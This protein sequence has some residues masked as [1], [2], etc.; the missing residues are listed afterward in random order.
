M[1]TKKLRSVIRW[2]VLCL[3]GVVSGCKPQ[4]NS[5]EKSLLGTGPQALT[6]EQVDDLEE[7]IL[8]TMDYLHVP[9]ASV[10]I[11]LDGEVIYARGFGVRDL[12]TK[13]PVTPQ[14]IM[15]IGST[16]K[17]MTT[18]MMASMVDEGI[19]S[20]DT[21]V[22]DI[23]PSITLPTPELTQKMTMQDLVCNC[24]GIQEQKEWEFS[25]F[26]N[27]VAEDIIEN[28]QNA[29]VRGTYQR[30]F[31]YNSN[32]I[33]SGGFLAALAAG[34]TYGNLY[35]AYV[36]EMQARLLD[37]AGMAD[38]TF[39][40]AAVRRNGNYATP[41]TIELPDENL[42]IPLEIEEWLVPFAP[43]AGLWSTAQDM[44][45]YLIL[46]LNQGIAASGARV[47]S[48][49]NLL[50]TW[51]PKVQID[52]GATYGLGLVNEQ[53][54]GL[55]VMYHSGG[56]AGYTSEMVFLPEVGLGIIVL[57]NQMLSAFPMAARIRIMELMFG[58]EPVYHQTLKENTRSTRWQIT[59]LKLVAI[60][61]HGLEEVST[62]LGKYENEI[63]GEVEISLT[64]GGDLLFDAGEWD[65][66]LWR[67]RFKKDTYIF[68]RGLWLG[69]TFKFDMTH[70][71]KV[72][73]TIQG[74]EDTYTFT[75]K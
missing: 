35:Q 58:L 4:G 21:P 37:P 19:F 68:N 10:A 36:D 12:E 29:R 13:E 31:L 16:T 2:L 11:V 30:S 52:P 34:G 55:R 50:Y 64:E 17:S 39:S 48:S 27:L 56:T 63:I 66:L 47:V 14:T 38:S 22:I 3:L 72:R 5:Q 18:L 70:P 51:D 44:A 45:N 20:W 8:D 28:L 1:Q 40:I 7:Y 60:K 59:Q 75:K 32:L 46:Q 24:S 53:Y 43:A 15:N 67:L 9:G 41:Y 69:K 54:H 73:F 62:L 23:L 65:S 74:N 57:D 26:H 71:E 49:E 61:H 6:A 33:A 42:A 25:N